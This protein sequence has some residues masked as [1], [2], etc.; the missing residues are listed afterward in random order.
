MLVR[1]QARRGGARQV[2]KLLDTVD[3]CIS[4]TNTHTH[5]HTLRKNI[6]TG[7]WRKTK[8]SE[9]EEQ[10]EVASTKAASLGERIL[11]LHVHVH[12]CM[13]NVST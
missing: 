5:T 9:K 1:Q 7:S 11:Q 6:V 4:R 2:R 10:E 12:C 13:L 3:V 8:A